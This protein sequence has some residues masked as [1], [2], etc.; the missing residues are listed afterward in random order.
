MPASAVV[1]QSEHLILTIR[2]QRVILDADLAA[3]YGVTTKALNQAVKR[4]FA[5]FPETFVFQVT[6]D[7]KDEVVTNC[8]HLP[9]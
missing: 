2:R 8:D 5:R 1:R 7:E 6:Q 4:N 3:L 9:G